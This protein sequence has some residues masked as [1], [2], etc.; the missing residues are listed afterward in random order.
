MHP[1]V[2]MANETQVTR[3]PTKHMYRKPNK[4]K[5]LQSIFS[6]KLATSKPKPDLRGVCDAALC[7][8]RTI[9]H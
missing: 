6:N 9:S 2:C 3:L 4:L 8:S 5:A 7:V 1:K